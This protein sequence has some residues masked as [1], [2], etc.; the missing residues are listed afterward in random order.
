MPPQDQIKNRV[1]GKL[2][3]GHLPTQAPVLTTTSV[4]TG[5]PC[6]AC[7]TVIRPTD[8]ECL[9]DVPFHPLFRLHADCFTEWRRQIA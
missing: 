5:A 1:A 8:V 2:A 6:A 4:G 3:S 7:S 9:C